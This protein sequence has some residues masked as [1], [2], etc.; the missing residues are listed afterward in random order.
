M[1]AFVTSH[2][3][4]LFKTIFDD[5]KKIGNSIYQNKKRRKLFSLVEIRQFLGVIF[6]KGDHIFYPI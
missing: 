3:L 6:V 1:L 4:C 5:C 2:S